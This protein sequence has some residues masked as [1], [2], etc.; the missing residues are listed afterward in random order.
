MEARRVA[1]GLRRAVVRAW[2]RM[3]RAVVV[4][5]GVVVVVVGKLVVVEGLL[6]VGVGV[7]GGR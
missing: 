6:G 2:R 5:E 3:G 7:E 1:R 4:V